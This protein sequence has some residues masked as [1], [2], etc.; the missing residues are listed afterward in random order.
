MLR[1]HGRFRRRKRRVASG[2]PVEFGRGVG[3]GEM[4]VQ[5]CGHVHE[6]QRH[7]LR[8]GELRSPPGGAE[9]GVRS[10]DTHDDGGL[11]G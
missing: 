3:A 9:C 5:A 11:A 6:G 1:P 8:G 4:P 10:V 7:P 2:A